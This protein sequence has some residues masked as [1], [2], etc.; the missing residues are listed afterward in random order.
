MA[1]QAFEIL[2][3]SDLNTIITAFHFTKQGSMSVFR[4]G[5]TD[6]H[7]PVI[8]STNEKAKERVE[9]IDEEIMH[10][11]LSAKIILNFVDGLLSILGH[12]FCQ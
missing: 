1:D 6:W 5:S 12:P 11:K 2:T 7:A 8:A 4:N 9:D 3:Y 10:N